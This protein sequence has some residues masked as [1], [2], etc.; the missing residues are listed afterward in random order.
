MLNIQ[1]IH[2]I[3]HETIQIKGEVWTIGNI[4]AVDLLDGN[5]YQ[6]DI[7]SFFSDRLVHIFLNR[8]TKGEKQPEQ[9]YYH[10]ES[11]GEYYELINNWNEDKITI[12]RELLSREGLLMFMEKMLETIK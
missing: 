7:H 2:K 6:F 8:E 1:N 5:Y 9:T 4:K 11:R 10:F 3:R 12:N